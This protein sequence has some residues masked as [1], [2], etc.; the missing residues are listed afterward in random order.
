[1]KCLILSVT[2]G[3]QSA[4]EI[5]AIFLRIRQELGFHWVELML[6]LEFL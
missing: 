4:N 6:P 2:Y 5:F 3:I 1:M